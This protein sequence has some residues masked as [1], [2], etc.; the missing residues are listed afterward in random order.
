MNLSKE[1]AIIKKAKPLMTA[2]RLT[3]LVFLRIFR[4]IQVF[5]RLHQELLSFR[6]Q[7]VAKRS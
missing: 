5:Y 7:T 1:N 4:Q 2:V 6:I 3:K